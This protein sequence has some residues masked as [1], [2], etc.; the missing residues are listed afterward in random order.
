M[1]TT[2]KAP[3]C[4]GTFKVLTHSLIKRKWCYYYKCK[5]GDCQ[6]SFNRVK[7]WN[8]HHL[9][10]HKSVK[11]KCNKCNKTMP[12]PS[13]YRDHMNL[14]KDTKFAC[15]KCDWKFVYACGLKL[16]RNLDRWVKM[17]TC[18]A[19]GFQKRYK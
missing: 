3:A 17:H 5:V 4:I 10:K 14:H 9:V 6:A 12:T 1:P 13:S 2:G 8:I 19:S 18:F 16:H 11:Y 7:S 15:N